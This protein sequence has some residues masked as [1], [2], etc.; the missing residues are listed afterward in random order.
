MRVQIVQ[1]NSTNASTG[2]C[3]VNIK[4]LCRNREHYEAIVGKL[5]TLKAV[6]DVNRGF[7]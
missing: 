4:I 5:K 7:A 2:N 6:R 3:V 1:I